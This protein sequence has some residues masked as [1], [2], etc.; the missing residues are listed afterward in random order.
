MAAC[1]ASD[2]GGA[3]E[4]VDAE[5]KVAGGHAS[6]ATAGAGL[7]VVSSKRDTVQAVLYALAS[8]GSGGRV[9]LLRG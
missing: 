5:G 3:G 8:A 9:G 4:A 1:G 7:V 2:S 6:G